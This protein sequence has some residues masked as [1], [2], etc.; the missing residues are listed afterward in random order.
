MNI[1]QLSDDV[2]KRLG[3]YSL[4]DNRQ[5]SSINPR[6]IRH[7]SGIG[8]LSSPKKVGKAA[9]YSDSHVFELLFIKKMLNEKFGLEAI[10]KILDEYRQDSGDYIEKIKTALGAGG[11]IKG[12][13]PSFGFMESPKNDALDFLNSLSPQGFSSKSSYGALQDEKMRSSSLVSSV[14][15]SSPDVLNKA[16]RSKSLTTSECKSVKEYRVR[17]YFKIS[18]DADVRLSEVEVDGILADVKNILKGEIK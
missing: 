9:D 8:L 12:I 7:Y 6:M 5:T 4:V 1:E 11:D 18:L 3:D 14:Y 2:N 15:G 10:K 13:A 17:D 16:F